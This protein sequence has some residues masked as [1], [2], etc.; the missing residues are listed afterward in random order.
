MTWQRKW[1]LKRFRLSD[2]TVRF[3]EDKDFERFN[4]LRRQVNDLHT[5][6]RPDIFKLG[7]P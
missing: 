7:I 6:G 4:E 3:A 1:E 5:E 2:M